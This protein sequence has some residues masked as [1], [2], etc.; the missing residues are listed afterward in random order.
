MEKW[1]AFV[2]YMHEINV[3]YTRE[4]ISIEEN[5]ID[6][7]EIRTVAGWDNIYYRLSRN[8]LTFLPSSD[9]KKSVCCFIAMCNPN[10]IGDTAISFQKNQIIWDSY[11]DVFN[12]LMKEPFFDEV[13]YVDDVSY[14][15]CFQVYIIKPE[16][17]DDFF[18]RAKAEYARLNTHFTKFSYMNIIIWIIIFFVFAISGAGLLALVHLFNVALIYLSIPTYIYMFV[19]WKYNKKILSTKVTEPFEIALVQFNSLQRKEKIL[20]IIIIVLLY[21]SHFLGLYC[22][23]TS[24]SLIDATIKLS[25]RVVYKETPIYLDWGWYKTDLTLYKMIRFI[26]IEQPRGLAFFLWYNWQTKNKAKSLKLSEVLMRG[27]LNRI[28]IAPWVVDFAYICTLS[29]FQTVHTVNWTKKAYSAWIYI[30]CYTLVSMFEHFFMHRKGLLIQ[31]SKEFKIFSD[32]TNGPYDI[33]IIDNILYRW[34]PITIQL[35]KVMLAETI[36][37]H[38]AMGIPLPSKPK[39]IYFLFTHNTKLSINGLKLTPQILLAGSDQRQ[40]VAYL[41]PLAEAKIIGA[42]SYNFLINNNLYTNLA[43]EILGQQAV[44]SM[45]DTKPETRLPIQITKDSY[46]YVSYKEIFEHYHLYDELLTVKDLYISKMSAKFPSLDHTALLE[47]VHDILTSWQ[48]VSILERCNLITNDLINR[49]DIPYK[50]D[51]LKWINDIWE[52]NSNV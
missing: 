18:L 26:T 21:K 37:S 36:I 25:L 45:I 40:Q 51:L 2:K 8:T 41:R 16:Y 20:A 24:L 44:L 31:L 11:I 28:L 4:E 32:N 50:E 6:R 13:F 3:L 27:L 10:C 46:N 12:N 33:I 5:R 39:E 22:F 19:V 42:P 52:R 43:A 1:T 38:T 30:Y 48:N 14:L 15:E 9:K 29:H 23:W 34:C 49:N 47:K 7:L 17:P 35:Y